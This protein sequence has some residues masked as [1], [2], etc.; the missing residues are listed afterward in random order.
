VFAP[1]GPLSGDRRQAGQTRPTGAGTAQRRVIWSPSPERVAN[2]G[3][4]HF[5]AW[6]AGRG[7]PLDDYHALWRWS[8]TDLEGFWQAVWDYFEIVSHTPPERVLGSRAM[9][10]AEWFPG[11]TLNY[12]EHA[13]RRDDGATAV[14]SIREDGHERE[15][16]F[17]ELRDRVA[18]VAAG[19]RRLGVQPLDRVAAMLPNCEE[20]VVGLLAAASIGA[21]WTACS[22][23][24]GVQSILERF[25]QVEPVVLLTVDGYRFAGKERPLGTNLTE[26]VSQLPSLRHVVA[27][28]YLRPGAAPPAGALSWNELAAERQPLRFEPVSFDHP[29]WVLYSSGTTGLPKGIVHGHGGITLEMLKL[30]RLHFDLTPNEPTMALTSTNWVLWNLLVSSLLCGTGIVLYDGS[31]AYPDER[32]PWRMFARHRVGI[33]NVGAAWLHRCMQAGIRPGDEFDLSA[34]RTVGATG[35]PLSPEGFDWIPDAVGP[36][37]MPSSSSG[38]TDV[39]TGFVGSVPTLPV[40]TGEIQVPML[41]VAV[42]AFDERG[43]RLVGSVGELVV[44]EPMPSMPIRL[45]NDPDGRRLRESYF[46]FYPGVWRHGDWIEFTEDG[47]SVIYGRSDAT[48]NRGGV[49]MGTAEFYRALERVPAITDSLI[50]DTSYAGAGGEL[51]LLVE[52]GEGVELTSE[53][54]ATVRTDLRTQLSPRHV[55]DRIL[56]VPEIPYTLTGKKCEIPV[57]RLFQGVPLDEA[58][59]LGALRNPESMTWLQRVAT[60]GR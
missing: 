34:L 3:V 42:G 4:T 57:K 46:D 21:V 8:V 40:R 35:S 7:R 29:L 6:L 17:A 2:A 54:E 52:L 36:H 5:L 19:F 58:V 48:L 51:L 13:L 26:I 38:G 55:P 28:D 23:E 30:G 53:L 60:D 16:S 32:E 31:P 11:A 43:E 15:L 39:C 49:R 18:E 12:A 33:I 50:V 22:P 59:S 56:P 37:V 20:A 9:P 27:L 47:G 41:G 14:I 45:W 1:P 24:N 25:Q 10:G 44:T